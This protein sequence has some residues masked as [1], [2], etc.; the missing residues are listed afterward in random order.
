MQS[1]G[2]SNLLAVKVHRWCD[3]SIFENQDFLRLAG[4]FRDVYVYSTAPVRVSDYTVVTD[5][6]N[7][8]ENANLSISA[9]IENLT[10]KAIPDGSLK[11]SV[12]L[13][14][15]NGAEVYGGMEAGADAIVKN[16]KQ[17]VFLKKQT[18][19]GLPLQI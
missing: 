6:D 18:T 10:G 14:D 8:F 11:A 17:T 7:A 9:D 3:G 4:I 15:Q 1:D 16:G 5:L 2:K 12:S 19:N 13:Y